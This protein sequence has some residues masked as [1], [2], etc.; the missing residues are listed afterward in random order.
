MYH[1]RDN[2]RPNPVD[3][4]LGHYELQNNLKSPGWDFCGSQEN[5]GSQVAHGTI[6]TSERN[7]GNAKEL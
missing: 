5:Q 1:K 3:P 2:N 7:P 6:V 4:K